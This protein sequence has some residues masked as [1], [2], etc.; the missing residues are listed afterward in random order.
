LGIIEPYD[1]D[2]FKGK[3]VVKT[4]KYP[5]RNEKGD[6]YGVIVYCHDITNFVKREN[7]YYEE[8]NN[9]K[10]KLAY[11][12]HGLRIP[13]SGLPLLVE[14]L[15]RIDLSKLSTENRNLI[16]IARANA[17]LTYQMMSNILDNYTEEP[18]QIPIE[19]QFNFLDLV[20]DTTAIYAE[21]A[22]PKLVT[23]LV[24]P[25]PETEGAITL[26][27]NVTRV[28]GMLLKLIGMAIQFFKN[29]EIQLRV[30]N[31]QEK[32]G[33]KFEMEITRNIMKRQN[34]TGPSDYNEFLSC[35]AL[36]LE[37]G[38]SMTSYSQPKDGKYFCSVFLPNTK[39]V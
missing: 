19:Q 29:A 8:L 30:S 10:L 36:I 25:T 33:V 9:R 39:L 28:R 20:L 14:A 15:E 18:P 32:N 31:T 7:D 17:N 34:G 21:Q 16:N 35:K 11:M 22:T 13:L 6:I 26:T 1:P 4:D 3:R 5:L 2:T 38:G 12:S 23:L 24:L 37:M 27:A